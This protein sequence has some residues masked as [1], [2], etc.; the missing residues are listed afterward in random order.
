MNR[1]VLVSVLVAAAVLA[2]LP[3]SESSAFGGR[4]VV[5]SRQVIRQPVQRVVV[6]RQVVQPVVVAPLVAAPFY[7]APIVQQQVVTPG[8]SAFFVK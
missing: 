1:F 6:Q 4:Q 8:C 3:Q 7:A 2:V 5:R